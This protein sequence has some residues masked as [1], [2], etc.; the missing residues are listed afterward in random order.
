M[1]MID[2]SQRLSAE[3]P[4]Y[5]GDTATILSTHATFAADGYTSYALQTGLHTGTHIDVPMHMRDDP[6]WTADFDVSLFAGRGV[7]LDVRGQ[8]TIG[9]REAYRELIQ[10]GDAVLLYTGW[11]AH[12]NDEQLYFYQHPVVEASL[13]EFL[14]ERKIRLLG[15]DMAAPDLPPFPVHQRLLARDVFIAENLTNLGALVG[16]ERFHFLALPLKIEAEASPVRA[17]ALV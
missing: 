9:F 13:T 5:P 10:E 4:L 14:V 1:M 17:V 6:R 8:K 16:E 11:D 15:V 7:L 2:L 12:Y 3:T